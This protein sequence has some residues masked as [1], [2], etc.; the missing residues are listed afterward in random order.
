MYLRIQQHK[1]DCVSTS[2]ISA[3]TRIGNS[4]HNYSACTGGGQHKASEFARGQCLYQPEKIVIVTKFK[5]FPF[6]VQEI[7]K[8][9][10]PQSLRIRMEDHSVLPSFDLS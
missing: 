4:H 5:E 2:S 8:F 6:K 9:A 3:N 1:Q 10:V 7:I